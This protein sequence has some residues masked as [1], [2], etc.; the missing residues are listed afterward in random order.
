MPET[1]EFK[2][3]YFILILICITMHEF[4][5]AYAAY[6]LG[7]PL[8]KAM[9][10]VTLNPLAH[11]DIVGTII[12]PFVMIFATQGMVLFGWGKPVIVSLPNPN[13][14]VRDDILTSLAGPAMNLLLAFVG[15]LVFSAGAYFGS[16]YTVQVGQ[17]FIIVNCALFVFNMLPVPPLDGSHFLRYALNISNEA[18][19]KIEQYG[20]WIL[21]ALIFLTPFGLVLSRIISLLY[22][23]FENIAALL[24]SI[25]S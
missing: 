15:T 3:L 8:P 11:S 14:R 17:L 10:R 2:I 23:G 4:G 16:K 6:K 18:Y 25:A 7:D 19:L 9:G 12:L 22:S 24:V 13:T 20:F 21:L 1:I 5:H